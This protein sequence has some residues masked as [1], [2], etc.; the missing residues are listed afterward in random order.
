MHTR[1]TIDKALALIAAGQSLNTIAQSLHV[2]RSTLRVW[3]DQGPPDPR[4]CPLPL[5]RSRRA[6]YS[7]LLGFYLGDGCLSPSR[8]TFA[9]RI[10]CDA[11]LPGVIEDVCRLV[12]QVHP[13]RPVFHVHAPGVIVVQSHWNHWPCL[14]PQHGPGRKHER[15]LTMQPWQRAIVEEHP[16]AFLRGLFHSDGARVNNWTTRMVDG[17]RRR[18]DYP[19]WQFR[20][21]SEDILCWCGEALD[22]VGVDWRRSGPRTLSVSRR[23]AVAR[24]DQLIGLKS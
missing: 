10:S 24:L 18:Y 2:S 13:E 16:A 21:A 5:R 9:L 4:P 15:S 23:E 19:R 3:R 6:N 12:A 14:F 17:E 1:A 20:N 8:R 11:K 22:Q 7:A